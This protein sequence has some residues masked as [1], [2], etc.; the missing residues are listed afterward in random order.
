MKNEAAGGKDKKDKSSKRN[1]RDRTAEKTGDANAPSAASK[2][3]GDDEIR[4]IEKEVDDVGAL[5]KI[6]TDNWELDLSPEAVAQ[7]AKDLPGEMQ[8]PKVSGDSKG[9]EMSSYEQLGKWFD[10]EVTKSKNGV[11]DVSD[12]EIYKKLT[13][14]GIEEKPKT[15]FVLAQAVFDTKITAQIPLRSGLLIKVC[16][17]I[18]HFSFIFCPNWIIPSTCC[19][20]Y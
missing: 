20:M 17:L 18:S 10:E 14:L 4:Q 15:L 13:E 5:K 3:D 1:R 9:T 12:V 16:C 19:L 7:R 11:S 8:R 6:D 2:P